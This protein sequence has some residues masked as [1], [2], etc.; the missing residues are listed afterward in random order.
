MQT[1]ILS[2][3]VLLFTLFTHFA[4]AEQESEVEK[5]TFLGVS[6][7]T[8]PALISDQLNLPRGLYLS[9]DQVSTGSPAEKAG[10]IC[11]DI[12]LN[13]DDQI[14]VNS[15]QLKAVVKM[16]NSGDSVLLNILR[17]G[18]KTSVQVVLDEIDHSLPNNS[19]KLYD[20]LQENQSSDDPFSNNPNEGL[21]DFLPTI[22]DLLN[23]SILKDLD[24]N[25]P[26]HGNREVNNQ[27]FTYSNQK[28]HIVI[29]DEQGKIEYTVE[30]GKKYLKAFDPA[31]KIIFEGPLNTPKQREKLP[32]NVLKK[33]YKIESYN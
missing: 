5:V 23:T 26:L 6:T 24:F 28:N 32:N 19:L 20:A 15:T 17:R 25:N 2:K 12:L 30:N 18:Q 1:L 31:G 29:N 10:I 13:F 14:L 22:S 7:S 27:A 11:N 8:L 3:R 16:K 4:S 21:P 33:L 9:V